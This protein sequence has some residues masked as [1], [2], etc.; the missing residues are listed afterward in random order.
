MIYSFYLPIRPMSINSYYYASKKIKTPEARKWEA[1]VLSHLEDHKQL[2]DMAAA[3]KE[4]GGTFRVSL[5]VSYPVPVYYNKAKEISSATMDVSNTEK[6]LIDRIFGDF[7]GVNDKFITE[8]YST[9]GPGG[10]YGVRVE[11][12]LNPNGY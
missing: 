11:L 9:K 5:S 7:M 4:N 12:E 8:M 6:V 1:E 3:H 2:L 10:S